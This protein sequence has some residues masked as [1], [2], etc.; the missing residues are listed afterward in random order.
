MGI[1]LAAKPTRLTKNRNGIFS[2]RWIVPV[3]LRERGDARREVRFSL[4][5]TDPRKARILALEFNLAL[6]RL[7]ATMTKDSDPRAGVTPLALKFGPAGLK[8]D[9]Q[10]ENDAVCLDLIPCH[11]KVL[12]CS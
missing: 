9:I 10:S 3:H 2:I 1:P 5:T 7:R 8:A 11:G 4:R 6:E 12:A